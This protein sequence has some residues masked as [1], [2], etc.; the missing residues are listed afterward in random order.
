MFMLKAEFE[1][2]LKEEAK[3]NAL[4]LENLKKVKVNE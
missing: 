2:Q 4:I 3:L 1:E